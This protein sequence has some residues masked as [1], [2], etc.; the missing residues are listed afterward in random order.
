[1]RRLPYLLCG[2]LVAVAVQCASLAFLVFDTRV[3]E[4]GRLPAGWR[5]RV[6]RG[7]PDVSVI[8]DPQGS[9]LR[10]K[11]RA[12]SFSLERD[13]DIDPARFP[14]LTWRWKV[15][16]LPRGGDFRHMGTDDQAAQV[17]V[18]FA[19]RRV[20]EYVWD[21]TAPKDT[22][23]RAVGVPFLLHIYVDVC[24]SG[25]AELNQWLPEAHDVAADYAR[26]YGHRPTQHVSGVRIQINSQHTGT[27]AESYFGEV[28]FRSMM[29]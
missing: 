26:A 21:T 6:N 20:L 14:Y 9:V 12:S 2:L 27:S 11:S 5:L 10:L 29:P 18:A 28:G 19:D 13:V 15:A 3:A 17:L 23:E 7:D 4:P 22:F 16:D 1:L 25:G 8:R 24:R